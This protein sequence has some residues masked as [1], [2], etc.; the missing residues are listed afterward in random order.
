ML[1][2]W[3]LPRAP[4]LGQLRATLRRKP[5]LASLVRT[6]HQQTQISL[7][8]FTYGNPNPEYDAYL[9]TVASVV[10]ACPN[11]RALSGFIPFYNNTFD[12]LTH[13]LASRP[14]LRQHIW[15][16]AENE[17]VKLRCQNQLTP[18]LLDNDQIH[19]S[20]LYHERWK[21]LETH[22]LCSPG[23][24][25][26]IEHD[27]FVD[28]LHFLPSLQ[29]LGV[30]SFD[31]E[32]FHDGTLLSLPSITALRLEEC[33]GVTDAGLTKWASSPCT[34]QVE[35]LCLVH[36]NI[37]SLLTLSKMLVSLDRMIIFSIVQTDVQLSLP[38]KSG[39]VVIQPVLASR[40]LEFLHWEVLC[41]DRKEHM[42]E[43]DQRTGRGRSLSTATEAI[44]LLRACLDLVSRYRT[45]SW[46]S[47]SCTEG[48]LY[49]NDYEHPVISHPV[50]SFNQC[51]NPW[52]MRTHFRSTIR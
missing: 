39:L 21:S 4:R 38:I 3:R 32:D 52:S 20:T 7:C 33:Y 36:Q 42:S 1:R 27:L 23:S 46:R 43:F 6:I 37:T 18:G 50:V 24:L 48:S 9:C 45:H 26:V 10:M 28:V 19:Q 5:L 2:R 29:R 13:A 30:C 41:I 8:I 14:K 40:S 31:A 12:R 34:A 49:C 15:V 35:S 47:Q 17:D 44:Q 16:I 51:V 25:G 22:F 11:L